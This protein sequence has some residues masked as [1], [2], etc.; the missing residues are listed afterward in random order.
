MINTI[1]EKY[2]P[3]GSMAHY[4]L[5]NHSQQVA[6]KVLDILQ[7]HPELKV[8]SDFVYEAAMLHDIGVFKCSAEYIHCYGS[9]QYIEHGYLGADILR[10]EGLPLHALVAERHT[11]I[12]ITFKRIKK[13]KL[14]L[15]H[16]D[17]VPLS[18]EEKLICY[19]DKFFS[20][21]SLGKAHSLETV[22][23]RILKHNGEKGVATFNE[24]HAM[25]S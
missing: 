4:V 13:E 16:R 9:H 20:K 14:P 19:A 12:G 18:L 23:S 22:K 15:P 24:W 21:S 3:T 8:D 7:K 10:L 11:G 17:L 25:F 5:V 6:Q 2:Y 1:I